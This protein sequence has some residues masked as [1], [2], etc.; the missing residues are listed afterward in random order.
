MLC[1]GCAS[2]VL[3]VRIVGRERYELCARCSY[4]S[5]ATE[6]FEP[7]PDVAFA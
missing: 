7:P 5:P 3:M 1:P 2:A 4:T 6:A